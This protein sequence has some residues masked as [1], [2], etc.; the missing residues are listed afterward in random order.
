MPSSRDRIL[1]KLRAARKGEIEAPSRPKDYLPVTVIDDTSPDGLLARFTEEMETLK[2][3]VFVVEGDGAAC[4]KVVELVQ[5][6]NT[7]HVLAWDFAHI[8]VEGLDGGLTSAGIRVTQPDLHGADGFA[9]KAEAGTAGAGIIGADYAAASTGTLIVSTGA[10]K[11]RA[12]TVLPPALIAVIDMQQLIPRVE[13]YIAIQRAA[14]LDSMW[15]KSNIG[16]ITGP[17]KTGDIEMTLV[18]GVHGPGVVQVVVKK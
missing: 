3:Q 13:D 14:G 17:S 18:L 9:R 16:F 10:G 15:N 11:S 4:E 6:Q 5:A 1:N 7:D 2:G 8:P 12:A